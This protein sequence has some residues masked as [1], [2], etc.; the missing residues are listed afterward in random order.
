MQIIQ[1]TTEFEIEGKSAVSI[2]KFDG[3]HLGHQKLLKKVLEQKEQGYK[4]VVFTFDPLPSALFGKTGEGELMTKQEKRVTFE[5]AGI[6]VLVEF[7]MSKETAAILPEDFVTDILVNRLGAGYI[8][9]GTDVSF[10]AAGAGN[11]MLL[12]A[13]SKRL[14]YEVRIIDKVCF[15]G[16]EVSSTYI[17]EEVAA[18]RMENVT[19]LLGA[20]YSISGEVVHGNRL[21]RTLGMPTVNLLPLKSKLLPPNGVYYSKVL[22]GK[23]LYLGITN[24]GYKPTVSEENQLGV[25]TYIYDFDEEIYGENITVSLISFK[26]PEMRFDGKD[27]LKKQM[28]KDIAEGKIFH[29]IT[30]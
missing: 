14:G 5:E 29:G 6:D 25:E 9:A 19:Q 12:N 21:G 30:G 4:A 8:V 16:R 28:L 24:I 7:P 17:R 15:N 22:L 11:H 23:E 2:G 3:I 18:G 20:P 10:G 13:M 26:R 27:A 1:G